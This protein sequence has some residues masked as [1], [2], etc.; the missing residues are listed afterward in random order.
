MKCKMRVYDDAICL[1]VVRGKFFTSYKFSE[2]ESG[3]V[4]NI[5]I[6]LNNNYRTFCRRMR[7]DYQDA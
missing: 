5:L 3:K 4:E 7:L 1:T 6:R 2:F